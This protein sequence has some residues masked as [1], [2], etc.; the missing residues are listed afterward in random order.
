M[1]RLAVPHLLCAELRRH[2]GVWTSQA[3]RLR[4]E[5]DLVDT[6]C[7]SAATLMRRD[8]CSAPYAVLSARTF[9]PSLFVT[10]T[11][12]EA[13]PR[14]EVSHG[15]LVLANEHST[16][17]LPSASENDAARFE[18]SHG[19]PSRQH[20]LLTQPS[21]GAPSSFRVSHAIHRHGPVAG[22]EALSTETARRRRTPLPDTRSPTTDTPPRTLYSSRMARESEGDIARVQISHAY[23]ARRGR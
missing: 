7:T 2:N 16:F 5:P 22:V 14:F 21:K 19:L 13:F 4:T 1:Q 8:N 23:S 18:L 17:H 15:D 20:I 11:S 12:A 10:S 9:H 6:A 3:P